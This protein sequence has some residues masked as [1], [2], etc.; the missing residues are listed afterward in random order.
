[1]AIR[2][3][4]SPAFGCILNIYIFPVAADV[5]NLNRALFSH[6]DQTLAKEIQT[7]F[8]KLLE[9]IFAYEFKVW[10]DSSVPE[11]ASE[12]LKFGPEATIEDIV[13]NNSQPK[14]VLPPYHLLGK[15]YHT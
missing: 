13:K 15:N 9:E 8:S 10:L 14:P 3:P 1:M 7:N 5:G 6:G 11:E 2:K 4:D 12:D